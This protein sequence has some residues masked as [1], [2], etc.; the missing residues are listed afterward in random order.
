MPAAG[1]GGQHVRVEAHERQVGEVVE[2]R[3]HLAVGEC[4]VQIARERRARGGPV[5]NVIPAPRHLDELDLEVGM[6]A[7]LATDSP[8]RAEALFAAL[9]IAQAPAQW[10]RAPDEP[11]AC[12]FPVVV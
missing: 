12:A 10:L 7:A 9:G 3:V 11:I 4:G 8:L 2:R 6:R 5:V 1:N